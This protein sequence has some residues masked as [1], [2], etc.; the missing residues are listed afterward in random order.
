MVHEYKRLA[1]L[2]Q[3]LIYVLWEHNT[4]RTKSDI[5]SLVFYSTFV[6]KWALFADLVYEK[7]SYDHRVQ[8]MS[9]EQINF[10]LNENLRFHLWEASPQTSTGV[11]KGECVTNFCNVSKVTH[12][13][14]NNVR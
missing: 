10:G 6:R 2:V 9:K 14:G 11:R 5:D 3:L 8:T 12:M 1:L 7:I 13:F 4:K